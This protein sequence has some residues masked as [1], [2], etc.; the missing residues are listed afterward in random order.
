MLNHD[1]IQEVCANGGVVI[2]RYAYVEDGYLQA[3]V[4]CWL[5]LDAHSNELNNALVRPDRAIW[6]I[7]LQP[8]LGTCENHARMIFV[9]KSFPLSLASI[10]LAIEWI[11]DQ[12]DQATCVIKQVFLEYQEMRDA[13]PKLD[14]VV[15]NLSDIPVPF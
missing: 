6:G 14:P 15:F 5:P 1:Q 12:A 2:E 9:K 3:K 11:Q 4:I 13:I 8:N 7:K 10:K